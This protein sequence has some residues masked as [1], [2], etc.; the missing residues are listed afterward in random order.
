MDKLTRCLS[1]SIINTQKTE[2]TKG[3][4]DN[5]VIT[6]SYP[7]YSDEVS[8]WLDRFYSLDIADKDYIANYEKIQGK[9]TDSL[10]ADETLTCLTAIVRGE[11]VCEGSIAKALE[12]GELE[13]LCRHLHE[14]TQKQEG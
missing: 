1:L 8:E 6:L 7:I 4:N 3:G 5:G 14:M 9:A 11:R 10:T 13:E 12:S 2:W